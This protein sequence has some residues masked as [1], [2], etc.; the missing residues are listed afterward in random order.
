M[1]SNG[2]TVF[3]LHPTINFARVGT[4][5]EYYL[6]PET[7]AG[8]PTSGSRTVGGLPINPGTEEAITSEDLRDATAT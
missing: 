4:S 2:T 7:S 3:R 6:S 1:P 5:D 8:L